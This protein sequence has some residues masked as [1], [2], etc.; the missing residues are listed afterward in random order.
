[1]MMMKDVI[2]RCDSVQEFGY[3]SVT[4]LKIPFLQGIQ[5]AYGLC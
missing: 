1:M 5:M 2:C 3:K 4:A